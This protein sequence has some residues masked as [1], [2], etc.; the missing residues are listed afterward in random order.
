MMVMNPSNPWNAMDVI[1][2]SLVCLGAWD[3]C[4]GRAWVPGM[5]AWDVP[6]TAHHSV[7]EPR[8][9]STWFHGSLGP[10]NLAFMYRGWGWGRVGLCA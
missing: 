5:C 6:R 1:I 10:R 3:V 2:M 9:R 8:I 7:M 4:L